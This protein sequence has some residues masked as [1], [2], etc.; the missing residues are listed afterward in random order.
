MRNHYFRSLVASLFLLMSVGLNAADFTGKTV[1]PVASGWGTEP[2]VFSLK[3]VAAKANI[4]AQQLVEKLDAWAET[5]VSAEGDNQF[6]TPNPMILI[7]NP[8]TGQVYA[9]YTQGTPGGFWMDSK[10]IPQNWGHSDLSFYNTMW[11]STAENDSLVFEIGQYPSRLLTGGEFTAHFIMDIDG[12]LYE[13]SIDVV[14]VVESDFEAVE[15]C[16]PKLTIVGEEDIDV[17]L[18]AVDGQKSWTVDLDAIAAKLGCSIDYLANNLNGSC[19]VAQLDN[20][21]E[22]LMP[23]A[24]GD[25]L[26]NVS[27][28]NGIGWWFNTC[29]DLDGNPSNEAVRVGYSYGTSKYYIEYLTATQGEDGT[30]TLGANIGQYGASSKVGDYFYNYIYII[31]GSK[32]YALKFNLNIIED[33]DHPVVPVSLIALDKMEKVGSQEVKFEEYLGASSRMAVNLNPV[34]ELMGEGWTPDT[35]FFAALAD[36]TGDSLTLKSTANNGGYWMTGKGAVVTW[37]GDGSTGNVVYIEPMLSDGE[38]TLTSGHSEANVKENDVFTFPMFYITPDYSKYYQLD[39][40]V[41]IIERKDVNPDELKEMAT[42]AFEVETLV[43][44]GGGYPIAEEPAID[45]EKLEELIGTRTPTFM[46]WSIPDDEGKSKM[47]DKYSCD[48]NPG[49]WCNRD[50]YVSTW[51]DANAL[52]GF[53]YL[54]DGRFDL[55]RYPG[56]PKNGDVW[57]GKFILLNE[58]TGQYVTIDLTIRFYDMLVKAEVVGEETIFIPEGDSEDPTDITPM[59]EALGV[60]DEAYLTDNTALMGYLPNGK[61]SNLYYLTD[62]LTYKDH[63]VVENISIADEPGACDFNVGAYVNDDGTMSFYADRSEAYTGTGTYEVDFAIA[64]QNKAYVYHVIICDADA[65]VGIQGIQAAT[66]KHQGIYTLAGQRISKTTKGVYVIGGK[67]V[68]VK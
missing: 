55:Y 4:T 9:K 64:N 52:V 59:L 12:G 42:W 60:E 7:E 33:E 41:T 57:N 43:N 31:F 13:I 48:P 15:T 54:A 50:G 65:W 56:R 24:R 49:F 32:A 67:K 23:T 47:T 16:F 30:Y 46:G 35:L 62:G 63:K 34:V 36:E 68:V 27:S 51:G 6:T 1:Q 29:T 5:F 10:G 21:E 22:S 26:T 3:E 8:A 25:T 40:T 66:K 17:E 61:W 19:Y 53:S 58:H 38:V 20:S 28:A 2:V 44:D 39:I 18:Y 14:L 37:S 11:W 45:L